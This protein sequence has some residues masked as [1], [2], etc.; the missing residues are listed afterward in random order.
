[1]STTAC[2]TSSAALRLYS[3]QKIVLGDPDLVAPAL[4]QMP[5]VEWVQSTWA[6][7]TPFIEASRR[8][9]KLT[10]IKGVFG[11]QMSEYVMGYIL[12][13][14]LRIIDRN[15]A[16][17]E[18]VWM[19]TSSGSLQKKRIG[20]MGT[21]SI[22]Q[23]IAQS[24]T[25]LGM[26]ATGLSLSGAHVDGF[27][28]VVPVTEIDTFLQ[29]T[30]YLVSVLPETATTTGLLDE[31]SL[32][33]LPAHAYFINVGRGNVVEES[34]LIRA[35]EKGT[36]AGAVLDVFNEEPLPKHSLLWSAPNVHITAHV[37]AASH[38]SLIVPIFL[39][40]LRRYR[41]ARELQHTV[42]FSKGY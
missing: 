28:Q 7:I 32:S 26:Q 33:R 15:A 13:H 10:G 25:G 35:L 12:A 2:E 8:N 1:M 30:D 34:A 36:L 18:K 27:V 24:A 16:Q 42:D 14:E 22:G 23:H 3:G 19:P 40:N 5:T 9:Y 37:A 29:S 17:C 6:G 38:V 21:G 41:A 11:E 39:D 4:H 31:H 20:I